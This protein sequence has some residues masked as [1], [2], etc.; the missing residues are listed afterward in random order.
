[1]QTEDQAALS[2]WSQLWL[3]VPRA[4]KNGLECPIAIRVHWKEPRG[5]GS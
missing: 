2:D 3:S 4:E 1:M 5:R